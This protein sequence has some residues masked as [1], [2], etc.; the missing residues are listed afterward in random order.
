MGSVAAFGLRG[1]VSVGGV[2]WWLCP[3]SEMVVWC[4]V[5][6]CCE[7]GLF[8]EIAGPSICVLY[9]AHACTS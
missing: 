8:V 4:Y 9:S 5:C 6:G 3:R 1:V 7:S 2:E